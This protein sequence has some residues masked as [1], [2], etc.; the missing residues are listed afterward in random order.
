MTAISRRAPT[1]P[2]NYKPEHGLKTIALAETAERYFKRAKDADKLYEAIEA[3]LTEQRKFVLWWDGSG[4]NKGG[5]PSQISDSKAGK[6]GVPDRST[7]SRWRA[8]LKDDA[9]FNAT[10]DATKAK[11]IALCE[12]IASDVHVSQNSGENEWYTPEIYITAARETLGTIDLDPASSL[13]ANEIVRAKAFYTSKDDGLTKQWHGNVWMNPPYA[14]GL[15]ERF[16]EKLVQSC[17]AGTVPAA[18]VLVNNATETDW[19]GCMAEQATAICTIHK[20]VKFISP[21]GEKGAPLQ[22]Q[23]VLYLGKN[24]EKFKTSYESFGIIWRKA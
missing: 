12:A 14:K 6:N 17:V 10:L 3:K 23:V 15:I 8:R 9:K 1:L 16:A 2:T 5:K 21:E 24:V 11:C 4:F 19:F 22:G 20:R 7:I 13:E 18:V